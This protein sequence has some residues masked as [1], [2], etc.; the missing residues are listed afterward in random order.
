MES[1]NIET[2]EKEAMEAALFAAES[3]FSHVK[4]T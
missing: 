1:H 2:Q 3:R 4:A